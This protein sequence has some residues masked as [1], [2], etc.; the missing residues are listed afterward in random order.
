MLGSVLQVIENCY[1]SMLI[2]QLRFKKQPQSHSQELNDALQIKGYLQITVGC[3]FE[4]HKNYY[5]QHNPQ[6]TKV[7]CLQIPHKSVGYVKNQMKNYEEPNLRSVLQHTEKRYHY[8][9][10]QQNIQNKCIHSRRLKIIKTQLKQTW[11]QQ[12]V[13]MD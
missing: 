10:C 2:Q 6:V 12:K 11:I 9:K 3:F 7:D 8:R 4:A 1:T 13:V 5:C